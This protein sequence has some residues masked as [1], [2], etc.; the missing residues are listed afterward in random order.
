MMTTRARWWTGLLSLAAVAAG[1]VLACCPAWRLGEMVRIADQRILVA[2]DARGGVEHFVREA[3][4]SGDEPTAEGFGFLVPTPTEPEIAEADGRVFSAL[5]ALSKPRIE[6][7]PRWR[8]SWSLLGSL[9]LGDPMTTSRGLVP[10]DSNAA[11]EVVKTVQVAG[12]E[13][14]VL[15]ADDPQRL[16]EWLATNGFD[17]RPEL[18]DWVAPYV[19]DSWMIT[20]FRFLGSAQRVDVAAVRMSFATDVPVFPFR[21]PVDQIAEAGQGSLLRAFVV[22]PG[23]ASGTLGGA[24]TAHPWSQATVTAARPLALDRAQAVEL[25][26]CLPQSEPGT[27]SDAWLTSFEDPTWPSG[28]DDLFFSFD[29]G[30]EPF[31]RVVTRRVDRHVLIPLD[32]LA[33]AVVGL[34]LV[35]RRRIA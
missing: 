4:F 5:E 17:S 12:Y 32:L 16:A 29:A 3:R 23:R 22:G 24:A 31:Q 13:A 14:V 20:A 25:V 6:T 28:T 10:T 33:I 26:E 15:R 21:V 19:A 30:G 9:F 8:P 18:I 34:A 7:V 2:Y 35:R 11:V 1:P 27:W